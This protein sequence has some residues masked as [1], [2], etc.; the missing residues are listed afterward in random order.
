MHL[1][2][3]GIPVDLIFLFALSSIR[4]ML[5]KNRIQNAEVDLFDILERFPTND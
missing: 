4:I 5:I 1:G 3:E 2:H